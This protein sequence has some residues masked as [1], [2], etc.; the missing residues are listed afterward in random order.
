M[1]L[2]KTCL[3]EKDR[4]GGGGAVVESK[5]KNLHQHPKNL[6]VFLCFCSCCSFSMMFDVFCRVS[7]ETLQKDPQRN[8]RFSVQRCVRCRTPHFVDIEM[9]EKPSATH[10]GLIEA[11]KI[12]LSCAANVASFFFRI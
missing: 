9:R 6:H 8:I 5:I 2:S 1:V 7:D 12:Q 3:R 10:E 4:C 11:L